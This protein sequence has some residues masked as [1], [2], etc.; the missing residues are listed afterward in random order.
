MSRT[1]VK[2]YD[3]NGTLHT[4]ND[5]EIDSDTFE[6]YSKP[7]KGSK[8]GLIKQYINEDG[9]IK[10]ILCVNKRLVTLR[11]HR[12]IMSTF[13]DPPSHFPCDV[14]HI[15]HDRTNNS[16]DNLRWWHDNRRD[17]ITIKKQAEAR[18]K[19]ISGCKHKIKHSHRLSWKY[20]GKVVYKIDSTTMD[21][22][23]TYCSAAEAGRS[24][25]VNSRTIDRACREHTKR[26][27]YY[28][29]YEQQYI[30]NKQDA[31]LVE[32]I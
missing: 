29:V 2:Y 16:I 20:Y 31:S 1:I 27:G 4:Y 12:I 3:E 13:A 8:G 9:Y 24:L 23:D 18:A 14:D 26:Y 7:R 22:V 25:N 11:L 28:W 32:H 19:L 17:P 15:D 10:V 5:Y 30:R 21:I 6:V